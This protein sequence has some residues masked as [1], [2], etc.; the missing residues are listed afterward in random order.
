M[1]MI[2]NI[3]FDIGNVLARFAW[4]K[5]IRKFGFS[6]EVYSRV[7]RATVKSTQW[8][9]YDRGVLSDGEVADLLAKNDPG[10]EAQI[11]EVLE[12]M[13]GLVER[14]DYAI[15]WIEEL[16]GKGYGVYYLSNFS[17]KVGR[18]CKSALDFMSHM[19]GGIM[20]CYVKLIKPQPEIYRLLL[21]R[22]N[23]VPE[24][25]VFLDDTEV[26]VEAARAQ[27]LYGIHFT[28]QE[29]ARAALE[30]LGVI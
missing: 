3:V 18:E 11:R 1:Q 16:K 14:L 24:E 23:L 12:D 20:S 9:E 19:D 25:C 8:G 29:A 4:E 27:G 26:N 2:Q 5:H 22:Y 7:V 17:Y 10:V 30:K 6:E 13:T 21:E 28:S 15:P